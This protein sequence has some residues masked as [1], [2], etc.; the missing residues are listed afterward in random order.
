M[1]K[2]FTYTLVFVSAFLFSTQVYSQQSD[3]LKKA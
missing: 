2:K 1:K 3:S